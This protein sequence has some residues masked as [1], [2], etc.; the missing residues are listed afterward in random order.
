MFQG[1]KCYKAQMWEVHITKNGDFTLF[2]LNSNL[3]V[4]ILIGVESSKI[5]IFVN[6]PGYLN[7]RYIY[8]K[9]RYF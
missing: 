1:P 2:W 6:Y 4:S 8:N 9:L 7:D 5:S 3:Y